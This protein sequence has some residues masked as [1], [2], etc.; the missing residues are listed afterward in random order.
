MCA[1]GVGPDFQMLCWMLHALKRAWTPPQNASLAP[2]VY[3]NRT[4]LA[5]A[6]EEGYISVL[7]TSRRLPCSTSFEPGQPGPSAQWLAHRNAIFDIAWCKV[8]AKGFLPM[9][10]GWRKRAL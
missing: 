2:Q 10:E 4:L 5:M 7:D 3:N 6:D 1:P 9:G 8:R